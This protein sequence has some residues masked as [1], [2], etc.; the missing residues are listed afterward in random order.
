MSKTIV[1]PVKEFPGSVELPDYLTFPQAL[2][3]EQ[4][5]GATQALFA[6]A[7]EDSEQEEEEEK[8]VTV[9][10]LRYD[11]AML[12]AVCVCVEKWNLEGLG[13]LAPDTFPSTPR[14]AS[15]ELVA[16]LYEEIVYLFNPEVP[17]E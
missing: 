7:L 3:Y 9:S 6:E 15:K 2:A 1:S 13:Q 10:Q 4:S 5:I 14:R 11:A 16:W 12:E 8:T 17:N